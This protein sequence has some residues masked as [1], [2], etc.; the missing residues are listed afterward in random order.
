M[1][2]DLEVSF[3]EIDCEEDFPA[4]KLMCEVGNVP[5][6]TLVGDSPSIQ[7]TIV[8]AGPPSVFL[9]WD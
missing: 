5:N 2:W 9:L 4:I 8:T 1:N 3:Y 7:N 6:W